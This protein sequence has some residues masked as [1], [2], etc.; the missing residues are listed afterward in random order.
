M[1]IV[2]KTIS[3]RECKL[4]FPISKSCLPTVLWPTTAFFIK[5]PIKSFIWG[6]GGQLFFRK[7]RPSYQE[8]KTYFEDE[9]F[10]FLKGFVGYDSRDNWKEP[11][12]GVF[13][14]LS[15][16]CKSILAYPGAYCRGEGDLRFYLSLFKETDLHY[17][18]KNSVWA[19]RVFAGSSVFSESSYSL[20]YSLGGINPF[21][22]EKKRKLPERL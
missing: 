19:L 9:L 1:T 2:M 21:Q 15:F 3:V 8:G 4:S 18:L 11:E 17:S 16:G 7:E 13:H 12:R 5:F 20:T 22:N 14:Q 6:L 10:L